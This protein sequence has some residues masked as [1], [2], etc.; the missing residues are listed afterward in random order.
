MS[1]NNNSRPSSLDL[2][3]NFDFSNANLTTP[4]KPSREE[5]IYNSYNE[6]FNF[7]AENLDDICTTTN[8]LD[9]LID[10]LISSSQNVNDSA[11]YISNGTKSE[12]EDIEQC[13]GIADSLSNK[14]GDMT[15][16]SEDLIDKA[17]N[18]GEI[19]NSGKESIV[20]LSSSQAE[21][22]KANAAITNA[23][24]LLLEKAI[25]IDKI[26]STLQSIAKQTNMLSLNAS[27][28]A[29]RAGEAGKGF[30]VVADEVRKLSLQSS[31]A[32]SNITNSINEI[33]NELKT[34]KEIIDGS[35]ATFESQEIAVSEVVDAFE[36]INSTIDAFIDEQT[37]FHDEVESLSTEKEKLMASV[38]R[39]TSV[40]EESSAT[41]QEVVSLTMGQTSS[42]NIIKQIANK[43]TKKLD[44]LS[45]KSSKIHTSEVVRKKT[46][47][48]FI[49][50]IDD[51]FWDSTVRE[52]KNTAGIFN[53]EVSFFTPSSRES[54][55]TDISGAIDNFAKNGFSAIIISPV[56]SSAIALAL[57]NASAKG[58]K[59]IFI[60]SKLDN[61]KYSSLIETNGI[62]LGKN[63]ANIA[64]Q[65]AFNEGSVVV[66]MWS[67][68]T[69]KSIEDRASG[70]INELK[71]TSNMNVITKSVL[72][73]PSDAEVRRYITDILG[74]AKDV[75]VVYA[76]NTNWGVALGKYAA[77][78]GVPFDIV[79]V[80]LTP[81]IAK[82]IESG[83]IKCAI[84]QRNFIWGSKPIELLSE[85][86]DG[87]SV[88]NYID[89]GS[90]AANISNLGIYK[91]RI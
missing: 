26:T 27:I 37:E 40:I 2:L 68:V 31:S 80:D 73:S 65:V 15:L 54:A 36:N 61:V 52:A 86:F 17:K 57:N 34:L 69:M 28:E 11:K 70:F 47:I 56:E 35:K 76:T 3:E 45:S 74:S 41:T 79:T 81:Q 6:F 66:G 75:K 12:L 7:Y 91:N 88:I 13:Q 71:S 78:Y 50:D 43:L 30:A 53:Y 89:T 58:I 9:K 18:M 16:K 22:L 23:I 60:S 24:Y 25:K 63:A 5:E 29:A 19:S 21:N 48:A 14:I 49:F 87:K 42:T 33:T 67:D 64:K 32:S 39:I 8:Q 62:E 72:S 46:K 82:Y 59:I 83:H 77:T 10:S 1:K 51:P 20:N 85:I 84:A 90:Y 4:N 38:T 44:A 55:S